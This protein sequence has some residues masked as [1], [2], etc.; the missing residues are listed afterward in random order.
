ME[1]MASLV[2][3]CQVGVGFNPRNWLARTEEMFAV[4]L[5]PS[6]NPADV[7]VGVSKD[8]MYAATG[9][10]ESYVATAQEKS[11]EADEYEA[12]TQRVEEARKAAGWA[13]AS[14][15]PDPAD[16]ADVALLRGPKPENAMDAD[17][18]HHL[19]TEITKKEVD[20]FVWFN[21]WKT[22]PPADAKTGKMRIELF[23]VFGREGIDTRVDGLLIGE[24]Y[25]TDVVVEQGGVPV[26]KKGGSLIKRFKVEQKRGTKGGFL[27]NIEIQP[28]VIYD[29]MYDYMMSF[30]R[31]EDDRNR[32]MTIDFYAPDEQTCEWKP[33]YS[34]AFNVD[35]RFTTPE[36]ERAYRSREYLKIGVEETAAEAKASRDARM[37]QIQATMRSGQHVAIFTSMPFAE[38]RTRWLFQPPMDLQKERAQWLY[39]DPDKTYNC[40]GLKRERETEDPELQGAILQSLED[41]QGAASGAGSSNSN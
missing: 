17:Q 19:E 12:A 41:A 4:R 15:E 22:G 10:V 40:A 9:T 34:S 32:K 5:W 3:A 8:V 29:I 13:A 35:Y 6:A 26:T 28:F 18:L 33:I 27:T 38:E 24:V 30:V 2:D 16:P 11:R 31:K 37:R 23:S 21:P 7:H 25:M 36:L 20:E 1:D 39:N 14:A